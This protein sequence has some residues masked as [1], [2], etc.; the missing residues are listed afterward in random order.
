[1]TPAS[2][3]DER[4]TAGLSR[5]AAGDVV[6]PARERLRPLARLEDP[7]IG[8]TAAV[9]VTLLAFFLRVWKLGTP[10]EFEFD[11]T[12]YAKDAW[13]MLNHGY[14]REYVDKANERIL[15]GRTTSGVWQD[16]PSMVVH[17]EV[18]KWLIAPGREGVRDGPVRL[19]DRRGRRRVADGAGADPAGTPPHRLD[20]ARLRRRASCSASTACTWCC[21]GWRCSTSSWRSS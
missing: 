15:D 18:G 4:P 13:S 9:A 11:E 17:P 7:I 20:D 10:R 14:V 2:T 21:P 16:D 3:L 1:M 5:T 12:Y 19:A 8:W 6:P